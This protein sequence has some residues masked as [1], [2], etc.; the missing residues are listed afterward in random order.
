[1]SAHVRRTLGERDKGFTL[2]EL[3]VV[4]IVIGILAAIAIPVFLNQRKK[5][6]DASMKA[7]LR[8]S[9]QA[10]EASLTDSPVLTSNVLPTELKA[11]KG[12]T[13]SMTYYVGGSAGWYCI[14]VTNP[15]SS[16]DSGYMFYLSN[17]GGLQPFTG[18]TPAAG[19]C[20]E[21]Y[22]PPGPA[23]GHWSVDPVVG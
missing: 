5:G 19:L 14:R 1:M 16:K 7:D 21:V 13:I 8:S 17:N 10:I 15:N 3:L 9:A 4:I 11:S 22:G 6:V 18:I 2:I 23:A 20:S 12:N